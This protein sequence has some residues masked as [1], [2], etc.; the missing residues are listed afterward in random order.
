MKRGWLILEDSEWHQADTHFDNV[1]NINPEYAPAYI[2]KLCAE[3]K[4]QSEADLAKC[5]K[6]FD[7]NSNYKRALRFADAAYKAKLEGYA[8][9]RESEAGNTYTQEEQSGGGT[10]EILDWLIAEF[11]KDTGIDLGQDSTA[12]QRL[13]EAS[14]KAKI[15]LSTMQATEINL[16]FIAADKSGPKHLV[17]NLTR[18][19][20]EQ[21]VSVT[22]A[23]AVQ[24]QESSIG[25]VLV[26]EDVEINREILYSMLEDLHFNVEDAENGA[27][28]VEMFAA[29]PDKYDVILMDVQMPVMDGIEATRRIRVMDGAKAKEI[30]IVAM[31][32]NVSREDVDKCLEA[33]MNDYVEKSIDSNL[34]SEKLINYLPMSK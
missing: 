9:M 12:L 16:S 25:T 13:R 6:P 7:D 18:A 31:L 15:E 2:G 29:A 26:A 19:E 27:R 30:P 33:G 21:I 11:K 8:Q 23:D 20:F 14:E 4:V 24:G 3:L 10:L 32:A 1:L 28:A 34:L 22:L 17:K 5:K